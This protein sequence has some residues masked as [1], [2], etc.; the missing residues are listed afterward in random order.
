MELDPILPC[1][2]IPLPTLGRTL[3]MEDHPILALVGSLPLMAIPQA[4]NHSWG[5][6]GAAIL[7]TGRS[8][9][10]AIMEGTKARVN[11]ED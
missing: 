11:S 6:T 2:P 9:R 10:L 3:H 8:I 7:S 4:P 5:R 1:C